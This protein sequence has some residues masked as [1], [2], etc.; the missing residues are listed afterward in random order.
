MAG[1]IP[2]SRDVK[3]YSSGKKQ[4]STRGLHYAGR[5]YSL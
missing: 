3:L 1:F 4:K 5:Y 2:P